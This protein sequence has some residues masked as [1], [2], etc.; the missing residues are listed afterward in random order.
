[1]K[2]LYSAAHGNEEKKLEAFKNFVNEFGTHY[3]A[4][5]ELGTKLSIERRYSA[6][7]FIKLICIVLTLIVSVY[8]SFRIIYTMTTQMVDIFLLSTYL[9]ATYQPFASPLY[10]QFIH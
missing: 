6:K 3:A 10:I 5:T 1:M 4:I 2:N 8:T 7:V 9:L